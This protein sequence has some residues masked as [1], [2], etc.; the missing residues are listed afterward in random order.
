MK[1]IIIS[2]FLAIVLLVNVVNANSYINREVDQQALQ[3]RM[4][5]VD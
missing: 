5:E 2:I 1:T 4:C 3:K